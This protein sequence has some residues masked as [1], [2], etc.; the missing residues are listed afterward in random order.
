MATADMKETFSTKPGEAGPPPATPQATSV[1][2]AEERRYLRWGMFAL[3]FGI[4]MSGMDASI[5]LISLPKIQVSLSASLPELQWVTNAYLLAQIVFLPS[6][7]RLADIFGCKRFYVLGLGVFLAASALCALAWSPMMLIAFRAL[8]GMAVGI[9]LP[10]STAIITHTFPPAS[11]GTAMGLW[12][13][14]VSVAA[15]IAPVIGGVLT[16]HFGWPAIF[17]VNLPMGAVGIAAT[18]LVLRESA[19][20]PHRLDSFGFVTLTVALGA[21]LTALIEGQ[22]WGWDARFIHYTVVLAAVAWLFFLV[23]ELTVAQPMVDLRLFRNLPYVG[24]C[25]I[26]GIATAGMFAGMFFLP[27]FMEQIL[28]Y[29]T[30]RAALAIAPFPLI[31]GLMSPVAGRLADRFRRP[32]IALGI[33]CM[34]GSM[35]LLSHLNADTTYGRIILPLSL[36]GVSIACV[37][38]PC[39]KISQEVLPKTQLG[40]GQASTIWRATSSRWWPSR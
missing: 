37:L 9:M 31:G 2:S 10:A 19:R 13:A 39:V 32:L 29:E 11:R 8:Q 25:L 5:V 17:L 14:A 28:E 26:G 34:V 20:V 22:R 3:M 21:C 36:M 16:E 12:M 27:L 38:V 6:G 35:Y 33:A 4:V 23:A 7:G 30:L 40:M 1:L 15:A 18:V 24:V